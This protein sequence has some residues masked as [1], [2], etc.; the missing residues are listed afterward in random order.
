MRKIRTS[1]KFTES[2]RVSVCLFKYQ[3]EFGLFVRSFGHSSDFI[4]CEA[5]CRVFFT[6]AS[7][8]SETPKHL[9]DLE[10]FVFA[11]YAMLLTNTNTVLSNKLKKSKKY[12]FHSLPFHKYTLECKYLWL[13]LFFDAF[14]QFQSAAKRKKH[15]LM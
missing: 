11:S 7:I 14:V 5:F 6:F 15:T 8:R 4:L 1:L 2:M 12:M 10:F 3:I 9:Y 13:I